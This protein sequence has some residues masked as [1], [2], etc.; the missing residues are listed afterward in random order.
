MPGA[1]TVTRA[2]SLS[3]Y[4]FTAPEEGW[5]VNSHIIEF[6][7]QLFVVDAQYTLPFAREVARYAANL[8]KPL[9]RLYVTHYH[10][11]HLLGAAAFTAPVFALDTV[12]QKIAKVGDRV[13][14]EEHEKVGDDIPTKAR[15]ADHVIAEGI[16]IVDGVRLEHCRLRC[17]ETADAL[18][19][20]M[21]DL[22]TI[23]V[24]DLVYNRAHL[25]LGERNFD[26]WRNAVRDYRALP[27][28]VVL[29]GHGLPGDKS[30]YDGM[31]EYLDFAQSALAQSSTAAEFKR[32]LLERFPSHG[33]RQIL[34]HE[35]RFLFPQKEK[36]HV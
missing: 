19:I 20:A 10:P 17:A 28:E 27:Y 29:P 23:I 15:Q 5:L 11:D 6:P 3:I 36:Q 22:R 12:A 34:D 24:Q 8:R 16:E 14:G 18:V 32:R 33:C 21:P 26:G 2:A 7:S 30:L 31:I 35:L 9:N 1:W 13:A 25:F 4:T